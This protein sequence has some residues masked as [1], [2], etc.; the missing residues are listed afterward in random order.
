VEY[1][2]TGEHLDKM[3]FNRIVN[4]EMGKRIYGIMQE[5][6]RVDIIDDIL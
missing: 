4:I 3:L 1:L 6:L 5:V 2:L